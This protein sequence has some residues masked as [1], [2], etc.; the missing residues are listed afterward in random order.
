M[1]HDYVYVK[2]IKL[3]QLLPHLVQEEI[4]KKNRLIIIYK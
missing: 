1:I 4:K 2:F 3:T